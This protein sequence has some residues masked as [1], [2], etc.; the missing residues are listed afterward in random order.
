MKLSILMLALQSRDWSP[1]AIELQRQIGV[2]SDQA[3]LLIELD[4]GERT[5][6][7]K[8]QAITAR[9]QGEY[10]CFI[11]DDDWPSDDYVAS[12]LD[13]CSRDV[14][15]VTFNLERTRPGRPPELWRF[16]LHD[17]YLPT[18]Q[19]TANHLCAWKRELATKVGW[20]PELGFA[21]DGC[22]YQPLYHS[23]LAK[24]E[25]HIDRVIYNYLYDPALSANNRREL[26]NFAR[27]YVGAGLR[28]FWRGDEILVEVG[29][30]P[31]GATTVVVRDR[32]NV[33]SVENLADLKHFYTLTIT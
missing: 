13:G 27:M 2:L 19:M 31:K 12:L 5:S 7:Q 3:E 4:G 30:K 17:D 10:I 14:D 9:A 21:D 32:N 20:C 29:R 8:R 18:G 33:E 6:G 16:G 24:T 25:H 23:R 22:W 26:K 28:C 15:V 1:L 11:D